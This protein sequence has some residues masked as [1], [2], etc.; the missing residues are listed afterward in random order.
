M[1]GAVGRSDDFNRSVAGAGRNDWYR[2]HDLA[3]FDPLRAIDMRERS[4][5]R[6]RSAVHGTAHHAGSVLS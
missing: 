3:L 1:G 5:K 4:I 6:L 2:K